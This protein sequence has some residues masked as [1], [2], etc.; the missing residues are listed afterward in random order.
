VVSLRQAAERAAVLDDAA[1]AAGVRT[2]RLVGVGEAADSL[3]LLQEHT[4]HLRS[5]DDM[6][7]AEISDEALVDVWRQL[8]RA[9]RAGLAHRSITAAS[10]LFGP[11]KGADQEVWLIGWEDGDVA[12]S[13]LARSMDCAQL[14]ATLALKVGPA[15][16]VAAGRMVLEDTYLAG[17]AGLL[18]SVVFPTATRELAKANKDVIDSTRQ[19]LSD[20][21]PAETATVPFQLV[22]FG[23]RTVLIAAMTLIAI[24]AVVTKLNFN[25]MVEAV[26]QATPW[27][28]AVSF[29][30]A[31]VSYVGAAMLM[32][33]FLPGRV[34]FWRAVLSQVAGSFTQISAPGALGPLALSLRFLNRRG[35]RTSL[36]VATIALTQV[37][38]V[39]VTL[40]LLIGSSLVTGDIGVLENLPTTGLLI[41]AGVL[42]AAGCPLLVPP[43]RAWI[44]NKVGPTF[45]QVW[46]RLVWVLG[47]PKRLVFGLAGA[48]IQ[49][50]TFVLAFWAALMSFGLTDIPLS[51]IGLVYLIGNT[52][53]S[54]APT[55]GGLGGV[56][57]ALTAALRAAG[58]ATAT[59]ASAALLF[60][61]IT[62]W[63]R[64][65]LGWVAFRYLAKRGDL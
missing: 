10:L 8:D 29:G 24:W 3:L 13:E 37:V 16:T 6:R 43:L 28:M 46:P 62:Y 5:T 25:Q 23:W 17:L 31:L 38:L 30:F 4:A 41:V 45:K 42:A 9:H 21:L 52:A 63:A 27:W 12:S 2:P 57:I 64:V 59:A 36:A 61:L 14:L 35:V 60:R 50:G 19:E 44:W 58:V 51:A 56:E 49:F 53:G 18:Q 48:A 40:L 34:P 20:L 55:P 11:G 65:P 1:A 47:R 54:A 32:V 22:R 7:P 15:R 33:G 39:V 26:G